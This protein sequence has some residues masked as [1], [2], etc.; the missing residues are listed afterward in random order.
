MVSRFQQWSMPL[1]WFKHLHETYCAKYEGFSSPFNSQLILL[2]DS[3]FFSSLFYDTDKYFGSVG[4]IFKADFTHIN[5]NTETIVLAPSYIDDLLKKTILLT[6]KQVNTIRN[7]KYILLCPKKPSGFD[8]LYEKLYKSKYLIYNQ[9][10]VKGQWHYENLTLSEK[11]VSFKYGNELNIFIF[12]NKNT[13]MIVNDKIKQC[14][15]LNIP[16]NKTLKLKLDKEYFR[17]LFVQKLLKLNSGYEWRN[18]LERFLNSMANIKYNDRRDPVFVNVKITHY[19]YTKMKN[20]MNEKKIKNK[21]NI[22]KVIYEKINVF[23]QTTQIPEIKS[24]GRTLNKNDSKYHCEKY[25]KFISR[26]R[27]EKLIGASHSHIY[28]EMHVLLILILLLRYDTILAGGQNWNL[29]F[30]FYKYLHT[31]YKINLEGFSSP[32]NSQLILIS[33][34][35]YFCSLFEDTDSYF[36]SKGN[37]FDFNVNSFSK[38]NNGMVSATL[39][40]PY[41]PHIL[42]KMV[43]LVDKWC[44]IVPKLR[45][46]VG[47]P[48]WTD[49]PLI[50][51][52]HNHSHLKYSKLSEIG[53][54]YF[55]NSS[56]EFHKKLHLPLKRWTFVIDNFS[57]ET[58]LNLDDEL[59]SK[60]SS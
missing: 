59:R 52:L 53:S 48:N 35:T 9:R 41:I 46:F 37:L 27:N 42:E 40:P 32:L 16:T 5:R 2:S 60:Y 25:I 47:F 12:E 50:D 44:N 19:V 43:D 56:N 17:Y 54:F 28:G 6:L 4:N 22:L 55:E 39:H 45:L 15:A 13:K 58:Y 14:L 1:K 38:K 33:P 23:L 7:I 31:K 21:K 29:P 3:C 57:N 20:E 10:L 36:G 34:N 49:Y 51:R 18:I 26:T 30:T 11:V 24:F 8:D